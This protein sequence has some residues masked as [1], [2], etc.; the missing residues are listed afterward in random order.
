MAG[1][2]KSPQYVS[3]PKAWSY[4][5]G[6]WSHLDVGFCMLRSTIRRDKR[7][8]FGLPFSFLDTPKYARWTQH[9]FELRWQVIRD[10]HRTVT[11]DGS[12][13][14]ACGVVFVVVFLPGYWKSFSTFYC[15]S[16][17]VFCFNIIDILEFS[18]RLS[19][20]VHIVKQAIAVILSIPSPIFILI[21]PH[22]VLKVMFQMHIN[23]VNDFQAQ[24][25]DVCLL[26]ISSGIKI[27]R[28][29]GR[30]ISIA[31]YRVNEILALKLLVNIRQSRRRGG[32]GVTPFSVTGTG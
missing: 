7:Y 19:S 23:T 31:L 3:E 17:D 4:I 1:D 27:P 11:I 9:D 25:P 14:G 30:L 12:C 8:T 16:I 26:K 13:D 29:A 22:G 24:W 10:S 28:Q 18:M 21:D 2:W 6:P 20:A 32:Y 15:S 5:S